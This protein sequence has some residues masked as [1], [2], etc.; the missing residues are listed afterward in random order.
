MAD[1]DKFSH[2]KS[3]ITEVKKLTLKYK[4]HSYVDEFMREWMV[5]FSYGTYILEGEIDPNFS[6]SEIWGLIQDSEY[7][8]SN[9]NKVIQRRLVNCMRPLEFLQLEPNAAFNF[10]ET[11]AVCTK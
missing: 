8:L 7:K 6:S 5:M 10:G 11:Q 3:R 4:N 9:S 2:L 1:E